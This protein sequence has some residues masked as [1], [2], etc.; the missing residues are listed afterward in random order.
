MVT[1]INEK[2]Y[3]QEVLNSKGLVLVDFYSETCGPCKR[4][5]PILEELSNDF[6]GKLKIMKINVNENSLISFKMGII[7]VPTLVFYK[8]GNM[9]ESSVGLLPKEKLEGIINEKLN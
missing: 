4:L 8:D 2:Q 1:N 5:A 9:V 6:D 3:D 7:S